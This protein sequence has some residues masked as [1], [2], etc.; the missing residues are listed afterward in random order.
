MRVVRSLAVVKAMTKPPHTWPL[1]GA[2][3]LTS[4]RSI[5]KTRDESEAR[6]LDHVRQGASV[7][8]F[9]LLYSTHATGAFAHVPALWDER[10]VPLCAVDAPVVSFWWDGSLPAGAVPTLADVTEMVRA[11]VEG[12]HLDAHE[13]VV[14]MVLLESLVVRHGDVVQPFSVRPVLLAACIVTL[15]LTRDVNTTT[16]QCV[17]SMAERFTALTPLL[18]ARIERQLLEYL[19]WRGPNDP[20]V[21]ERVLALLRE[22][23]PPNMLPPSMM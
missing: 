8:L 16:T 6:I 10:V 11:I 2:H 13:V 19:D 17:E 18:G 7:T 20:A 22:A 15:K 1:A 9:S 4:K 14:A 3:D 21:Y 12:L 23:T 5:A